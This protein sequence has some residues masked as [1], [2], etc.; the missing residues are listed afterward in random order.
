MNRTALF[1]D[2][3][4]FFYAQKNELQW[5]I[6]PS[7]LVAFC[8]NNFGQVVEAMYYVCYD[9]VDSRQMSFLKAIPYLG[10]T[11]VARQVR[12]GSDDEGEYLRGHR[13]DAEIVSDLFCLQDRYDTAALVTGNVEMVEPIRKLKT[14]GKGVEIFSTTNMLSNELREVVGSH[15]H[16]FRHLKSKLEKA[17]VKEERS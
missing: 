9:P 4:H 3:T 14:L 8:H 17:D 2:G 15:F 1:L 6:D 13:F 12:T 11:L 5:R 7:K 16:D 10:Y